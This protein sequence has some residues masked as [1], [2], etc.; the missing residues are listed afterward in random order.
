M[1]VGNSFAEHPSRQP[2]LLIAE[3]DAPLAEMLRRG[4]QANQCDVDVVHDGKSAFQAVRGSLYD[5][6]I[7]D[8]TLPGLDGLE[9][10]RQL[11]PKM[12]SL[13]VLVIT[14]RT[15]LEDRIMALDGGADDCLIKPFSFQ[16][17][18]AR[19]RALLRRSGASSSRR[20]QVGDLVLNRE[21]LRVERSGKRIDL[22]PKEFLV[23]ECLMMHARRPVSRAAL[24]QH[25]WNETYDART[26]LVDVYVK[27]VRDKIDG[28]FPAKLIRTIRSVG[29]VIEEN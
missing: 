12:P 11:R 3:D 25:V 21:D 22:T 20:L 16:E 27:Y 5:L 2:H 29:Y 18:A 13:P 17:F 6:L 19:T 28:G 7:L 14:G 24:M 10:L 4:L 8:L 23:L 26:N 15:H 1:P 9:L